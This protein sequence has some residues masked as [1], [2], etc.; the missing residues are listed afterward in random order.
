MI[1]NSILMQYG[2]EHV[3]P[4]YNV[5]VNQQYLSEKS[6]GNASKLLERYS[7]LAKRSAKL[8]ISIYSKLLNFQASPKFHL[9]ACQ[10]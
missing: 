8:N 10:P 2:L 6:V 7:T 9:P 3:S 5:V 1:R 4:S